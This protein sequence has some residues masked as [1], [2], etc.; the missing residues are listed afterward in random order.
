LA[1]RYDYSFFQATTYPAGEQLMESWGETLGDIPGFG[2]TNGAMRGAPYP[3]YAG[4]QN[5]TNSYNKMMTLCLE[6]A[7]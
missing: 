7:F 2:G 4:V 5:R 6:I 3:P 1:I